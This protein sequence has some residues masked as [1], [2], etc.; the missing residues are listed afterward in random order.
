M[1]MKKNRKIIVI[2]GIILLLL[3]LINS[4]YKFN[5]KYKSEDNFSKKYCMVIRIEKVEDEKITYLVKYNNNNFLLNIYKSESVELKELANF[6]YGDVISYNGKIIIPSKLNNPYEFNY[7]LYLNSNDI[8]GIITCYNVEKV[9]EKLGNLILKLG[10]FLRDNITYRIDSIYEDDRLELLKTM[11][12]GE[13]INLDKNI[14]EI[15]KNNGLS[16]V[17]AVSGMHMTYLLFLIDL[18]FKNKNSK[19]ALVLNISILVIFTVISALSISVIRACI[20]SLLTIIQK[21]NKIKV[22]KYVNIIIAFFIIITINPY[23]I[24]SISFLFSFL[25]TFGII[26]LYSLIYSY[27][28]I[29]FNLNYVTKY[30]FKTISLNVSSIIMILPLQ[31]YFTGSF[32]LISILS[33]LIITPIISLEFII[34]FLTLLLIFVPYVSNILVYSNLILLE[35]IIYIL[36]FISKLNYFTIYIP[37]QS[38]FEIF[39]YYILISILSVK[40]Y[41]PKLFNKKIKKIIRNVI[42]LIT[43]FIILYNISMYIYRVYFEE[44]IYFFNVGQGNMAIIREDRKV[45]IFDIGST[46]ENLAGNILNNFLKAKAISK[47]DAIFLTHL[48]DDHINGIY[49]IIQ[50]IEINKVYYGIPK[51][52]EDVIID[53]L[54]SNNIA[55]E[56]LNFLDEINIGSISINVLSPPKDK[57][58]VSNDI[59]NSNSLVLL[60]KTKHK[61]ILFMGDSTI[62]TEEEL[63]KN[64]DILE[65]IKNVDAI[66]IG[67]HGSKTSSSNEFISNINSCV[68]IISS[69]KERFGHPNKEVL[70]TLNRYKFIIKITQND[71]AFKLK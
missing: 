30:V 6:T 5:F 59:I 36:R 63:L 58:I 22:N 11:I 42:F 66:Q 68:A 7:K 10:Y 9:G 38:L 70:D 3:S 35:V 64:K 48:H 28:K 27:L 24:F 41:I 50:N 1:I 71:G 15:F 32:E 44:Y 2:T 60:V 51:E 25:S 21:D 47:I 12:Y 67:H 34:G 54:I 26:F 61:K 57:I 37:M 39:T 52:G 23:S 18:L 19:L 65:K 31:I 69:K 4:I 20:M 43:I 55:K 8:V 62:E 46:Q 49:D 29:K 16:H 40:K 45:I 53:T 13:D 14:E 56:N 17:L 33:N